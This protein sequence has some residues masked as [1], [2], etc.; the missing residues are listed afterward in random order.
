MR[1]STIWMLFLT[2]L[3][4][5]FGLIDNFPELEFRELPK[6]LSKILIMA[7]T[8]VTLPV[9]EFSINFLLSLIMFEA[10]LVALIRRV[11]IDIKS[12]LVGLSNLKR[13][14]K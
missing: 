1:F 11:S 10:V 9:L 3:A 13:L 8:A 4:K 14:S 5:N 7:A 2:N 6:F 12:M